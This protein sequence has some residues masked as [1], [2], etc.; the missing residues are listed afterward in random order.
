MSDVL[1]VETLAALVLVLV[2]LLVSVYLRKFTEKR[3]VLRL[4]HESGIC[5]LLGMLI[6]EIFVLTSSH[7]PSKF[8]ASLFFEFMLP[9]LIFGVGYNMKRRRFFRNIGPIVLNGVIGTFISFILLSSLIWA[10]GSGHLVHAKI[11]LQD[12]LAL[13]A[14]LSCPETV[15]T[16]SAIRETTNP[17]LNSIIFGE[18]LI[19]NAISILLISAINLVNFDEFTPSN[20][21]AF[22]GYILYSLVGS[23]VL[24]IS[25][26]FISALMTKHFT[27][28]KLNPNK[29]VALQFYIAWTGYVVATM[30]GCS[31]VVTILICAIITSHYAYYN[32][33]K[34]SRIVVADT[35]Q[36]FGDGSRALIFGYLG[37]TSLS[38]S[39]GSVAIGLLFS[40]LAAIMA[41]RLF[42]VFGLAL[43]MKLIKPKYSLDLKYLTVIWLG[44]LFRGTIAFALILSVSLN[45]K[46][47]IQVTVL[48]TIIVSMILYTF[49]LPLLLYWLAPKE[50]IIRNQ[51]ILEAV[52]DGY[53]RNSYMKA[54][55]ANILLIDEYK[56]KR[57]W[58]HAKWRDLD[59][60]YLKPCLI[61]K[62]ALEELQ[63]NKRKLEEAARPGSIKRPEIE[64]WS[65]KN[66]ELIM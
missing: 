2:Y 36:L 14:V 66:S 48:Y 10:F 17:K 46:D 37:L 4:V 52:A 16:L 30:I 63:E 39:T 8:E 54:G 42:T 6:S 31:G 44:G 41:T 21:F 19:G 33:T 18:S 3:F 22:V 29:E 47:I 45:N 58:I 27:Q 28:I 25:L 35:F 15:V 34:E 53:Y 5:I 32:M 57:N 65:G 43:L 51:S 55:E 60:L 64:I 7:R 50:D 26:G 59:N 13:G 40:I 24:G 11:T 56:S 20:F 23:L 38:Y 62:A 1:A 61:D 49:I 9:F 12:S